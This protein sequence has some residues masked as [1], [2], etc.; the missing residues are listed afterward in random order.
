MIVILS[1]YNNEAKYMNDAVKK[2]PIAIMSFD[3]PHYLKA[4]LHSLRAQTIPINTE[5][6]FLFQDGYHSKTGRDLTNPKLVEH[7]INLFETIFPGGKSFVSIKNLGV[8]QNFARAE[9]YFFTELGT[10][11]AFFF[12]DD[13]VLSPH[14]LKALYALTDIALNERRIAY[15]AAYGNHRATLEEQRRAVHRL[16][17]MRHKWGFALT[18]RQW[19]AQRELLEPYL[20]IVARSDYRDRDHNAIQHYFH[21]L[22]YGSPGTSQD[23]MKDVASCVLGTTKVMTFACLGKYIGEIGLH[24]QKYIYDEEKFGETEIYPDEVSSFQPPSRNQLDQWIAEDQTNAKKFLETTMYIPKSS[25]HYAKVIEEVNP[26]LSLDH[27]SRQRVKK[28]LAGPVEW[29]SA[30]IQSTDSVLAVDTNAVES[31]KEKNQSDENVC[32][33]DYQALAKQPEALSTTATQ[34]TCDLPRAQGVHQMNLT[35]LANHFKSDKGTHLGAPPHRYTYLYDLLFRPLKDKQFNLLEIGLAVGGPEVGGPAERTVTSPSIQ[36]WLTYFSKARVF[37]FDISDFSHISDPRF[38]F[39]RGDVGS[40]ADLNRLAS[41]AEAFD[42]II[43]DASHASYHQQ[44]AFKT[45]FPKLGPGG[46]YIIEDLHWQPPAFE[47]VLPK[48]P[49]TAQ[50]LIGFFEKQEYIQ[51]NLLS[52][53][54]MQDLRAE[55][56]SFASF[57]AFDGS[58]S[59]S[60]LIVIRKIDN[61][62]IHQRVGN[63]R[64]LV[65][66]SPTKSTLAASVEELIA[67]T[68]EAVLERTPDPSGLQAYHNAFKDVSLTVGLERM[69]KS[70]LKSKEFQSKQLLKKL[71]LRRTTKDFPQHKGEVIFLQTAD[72]DEYNEMLHLS[73]KTVKAFCKKSNFQYESH[74]GVIRG[75]YSWQATFNRIPMLYRLVESGFFGWTCYLDADAFIADLNFDLK[76]YLADKNDIALI[77]ARGGS[78]FWWAINAGVLFIN[79]GHP[80]G[81]AITREWHSLFSAITDDELRSAAD[82]SSVPDDQSLLHQV[83]RSMP[84]IENHIVIDRAQPPLINYEGRFIKQVLRVA[85]SIQDRANKL[86]AEV[87]QLL[88]DNNPHSC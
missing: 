49:K 80:L 82:W 84:D 71:E 12:E 59:S 13:L 33:D 6:I 60:K 20:E 21:K 56:A 47:G 87:S 75:Y 15:V 48:V 25:Y 28:E 17:P 24:S 61:L 52:A 66:N 43:D 57:G 7:C 36:M 18:H 11:A 30:M 64:D 42:V 73:S 40:E 46:L 14:Y 22:G 4:V 44:L 58:A 76:E 81:R 31:A 27:A 77:A 39:I 83:L 78:N 63:T 85:G 37:G 3:R 16:L 23:S 54:Y 1:E 8:A 88:G 65:K 2:F 29:N 26:M 32:I 51:N 67:A 45:L 68:Y 53:D 41:S 55:V 72:A 50:F 70:L 5:E 79:L 38:T 35:E 69:L 34:G 62:E 74:L 9:N 10:T 19:D 86:R